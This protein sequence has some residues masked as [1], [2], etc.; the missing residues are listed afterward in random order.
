MI[1]PEIQANK[2]HNYNNY[3]G[4]L[5]QFSRDS[6]LFPSHIGYGEKATANDYMLTTANDFRIPARYNEKRD[7]VF[8]TMRSQAAFG[9]G[10]PS[11]QVY[12]TAKDAQNNAVKPESEDNKFF[13][14]ATANIFMTHWTWDQ[15]GTVSKGMVVGHKPNNS[16]GW[17]QLYGG[18]G[19]MLQLWSYDNYESQG[20]FPLY[21][22][23]SK[24]LL[25]NIGV[26][27][28]ATALNNG[29][30]EIQGQ[31][32]ADTIVGG[33]GGQIQLTGFYRKSNIDNNFSA[34]HTER[35]ND[36]S[37]FVNVEYYMYTTN[38]RETQRP[39]NRN[40]H[41]LYSPNESTFK[42]ETTRPFFK[43]F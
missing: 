40:R 13:I 1:N 24:K 22:N 7:D 31:S 18:F 33:N 19:E 41:R 14:N 30:R 23:T 2:L 43:N 4:K 26:S 28:L 8:L 29:M 34:S 21:S 20:A 9:D 5:S 10:I 35:Q 15:L 42:I 16:L 11:A 27:S 17:D 12:L 38:S 6:Y 39:R 36:A 25:T 3:E 32:S 37:H